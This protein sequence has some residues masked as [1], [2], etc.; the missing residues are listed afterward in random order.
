VGTGEKAMDDARKEK[1]EEG[2][3]KK[4]MHDLGA[5]LIEWVHGWV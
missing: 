3:E 5:E 2:T 4:E 1:R